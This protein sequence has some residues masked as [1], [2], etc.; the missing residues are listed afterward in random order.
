MRTTR[1]VALRGSVLLAALVAGAGTL[2]LGAAPG[3]AAGPCP[4]RGA[5]PAIGSVLQLVNSSA[6]V[7]GR[8]VGAAPFSIRADDTICTDARGQVVFALTGSRGS[9][10]ACIALPSSRIVAG[11]RPRF[12]SGSS[13]CVARGASSRLT[14]AS[15]GVT[16][17]KDSL[18]GIS[19]LGTRTLVKVLTGTVDTPQGRIDR[20]Y[21]STLAPGTSP[22]TTVPTADDRRA[23]AQLSAALAKPR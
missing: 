3:R 17:G 15:T 18:F 13:W 10:T 11:A 5:G 4:T 9:S 21:Q 20:L 1:G 16:A 2:A 23:I 6:F 12:E 19:V 14:V 8:Y 7:G 22:T